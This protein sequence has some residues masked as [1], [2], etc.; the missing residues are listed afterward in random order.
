VLLHQQLARPLQTARRLLLDA[1]DR[2][3]PHV[4]TAEGG[5]DRLGVPRVR[6]VAT[7][8]RLSRRRPDSA[9]PRAPAP[10]ASVP[11]CA[12]SRTPRCRSAPAAAWQRTAAPARG[13][14]GS[15]EPRPHAVLGIH[16]KH[17]F[18]DIQADRDTLH[19]GRS[20]LLVSTLPPVW[21]IDAVRGPSVHPALRTGGSG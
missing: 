18:A 4:R 2:N 17:R 9:A 1:L 15:A 3:E 13:A 11:R 21:H 7:D 20:P 5:A 6:L 16:L 14:S 19:R 12:P 8:E 10:A